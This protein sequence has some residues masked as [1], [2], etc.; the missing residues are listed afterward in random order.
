MRY[1][2]FSLLIS[3]LILPANA[4]ELN[5][6]SQIDSITLFQSG[7]QIHRTGVTQIQA[8]RTE[9]VFNGLSSEIDENSLRVS[10]IGKFT[11]LSVSFRRNFLEQ[12]EKEESLVQL[13]DE[14]YI[15]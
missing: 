11:I 6:T 4:Q 7:A 8:G 12:K 2:L 10:G 15:E 5:V 1:T 13:E 9:V 3:F 14:K